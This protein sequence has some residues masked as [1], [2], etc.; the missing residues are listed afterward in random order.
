MN[1]KEGETNVARELHR[2]SRYRKAKSSK[3]ARRWRPRNPIIDLVGKQVRHTWDENGMSFVSIFCNDTHFVWN[4]LSNPDDLVTGVE[5]YV[6]TKISD[7][8]VQYSWKESPLERDFGIAWTFNFRTDRVY[9]MIV[10]VFPDENL[11]L[12]ADYT[13]RRGLEVEDGLMTC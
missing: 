1:V 13:I 6:R 10:N 8:V 7:E 9:G 5:K 11:N 2:G 12:S 4:D 3:Y